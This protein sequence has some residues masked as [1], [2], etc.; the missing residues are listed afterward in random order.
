MQLPCTVADPDDA[1]VVAAGTGAGLT[2]SSL[3]LLL[4][5]L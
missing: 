1:E 3:L 4:L 2:S 5:L